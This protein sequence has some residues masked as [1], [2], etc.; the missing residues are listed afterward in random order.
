MRVRDELADDLDIA[1]ARQARLGTGGRRGGGETPLP[2]APEASEAIWILRTALVGW[3]RVLEETDP[4]QPT[5]PTCSTCEHGSCRLITYRTPAPDTLAGMADW[6][7][8]RIESLRHHEAAGEAVEEITNAVRQ[9]THAIDRP[10]DRVYLGICSVSLEGGGECDT[11]LYARPHAPVMTCLH[12]G[13]QHSIQLRRAILLAA[14]EDVLGTATEVARALSGLGQ[15]V[16]PSMIRGY[17]HRGRLALRGTDSA[18]HPLYR[19]GDVLALILRE[20]S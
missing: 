19:L 8:R 9:A 2:Y 7:T 3:I 1:L 11:D 14:A 4:A 10:A 6:L 20:V 12:C 16:T 5:G 15:H 18:D 13:T 17:A